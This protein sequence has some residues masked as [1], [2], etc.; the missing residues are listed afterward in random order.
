MAMWKISLMVRHRSNAVK[1]NLHLNFIILY[2]ARVDLNIWYSISCYCISLFLSDFMIFFIMG[3]ADSLLPSMVLS[4]Q[5]KNLR[6]INIWS[7][8]LM[9]RSTGRNYF[10]KTIQSQQKNG[11]VFRVSRSME[12]MCFRSIQNRE[13]KPPNVKPLIST[14]L[15]LDV[16][17]TL[18]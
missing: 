15:Q 18:T 7:S 2:L 14:N 11:T 13:E 12:L 4:S 8:S 16:D 5:I 1:L 3:S 9:T 10:S 6:N 17:L